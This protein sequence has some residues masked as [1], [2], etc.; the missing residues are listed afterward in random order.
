MNKETKERMALLPTQKAVNDLCRD[1]MKEHG[2]NKGMPDLLET[3]RVMAEQ[4]MA[5]PTDAALEKQYLMWQKAVK[6]EID[7]GKPTEVRPVLA[8]ATA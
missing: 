8:A 1:F 3:L 6:R 2:W 5:D 4:T 7:R